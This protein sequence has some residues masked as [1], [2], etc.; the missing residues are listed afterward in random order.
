MDEKMIEF[1]SVY[2]WVCREFVWRIHFQQPFRMAAIAMFELEVSN[3]LASC[4]ARSYWLSG[5]VTDL[6]VFIDYVETNLSEIKLKGMLYDR[7]DSETNYAFV[8]LSAP[9]WFAVYDGTQ[10]EL[11]AEID[12]TLLLNVG[13]GVDWETETYSGKSSFVGG[14]FTVSEAELT[15]FI[16]TFRAFLNQLP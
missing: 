9:F 5:N 2:E 15:E 11:G 10:T 3:P 14:R 12:I 7:Y 13:Q 8:M 16:T 4:K 6:Q 1:A